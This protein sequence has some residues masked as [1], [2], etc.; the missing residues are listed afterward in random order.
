MKGKALAFAVLSTLSAGVMAEGYST[1][2]QSPNAIGPKTAIPDNAAI[3]S[4][5]VMAADQGTIATPVTPNTAVAANAP[6]VDARGNVVGS[7]TVVQPNPVWVTRSVAQS[8]PGA[9]DKTRPGYPDSNTSHS[10]W[11]VGTSS[12]GG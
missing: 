12:A 8:G 10:A 1:Y 7:T 2:Q 9:V 4:A 6:V 5:P 3:V 11:D